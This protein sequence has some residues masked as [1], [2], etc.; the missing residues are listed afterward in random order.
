MAVAW[1][2][3]LSHN[4]PLSGVSI[5]PRKFIYELILESQEVRINFL[6]L[7]KAKFIASIGSSKGGEVDKFQKLHF[8]KEKPLKTTVLLLKYAYDAYECRLVD[9]LIPTVTMNDF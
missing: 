5:S 9:H 3:L 8:A 1:H 2:S 4:P 7:E 6:P